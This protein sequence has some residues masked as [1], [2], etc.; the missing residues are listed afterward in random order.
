MDELKDS[1]LPLQMKCFECKVPK[2]Q[3]IALRVSDYIVKNI[4]YNY[5]KSKLLPK[6]LVCVLDKNVDVRKMALICLFNVLELIDRQ[7]INEQ[8]LNTLEK[9]KAGLTT[10]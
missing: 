4:D 9:L 7:T 2:L 1:I 3:D 5:T 8:V 6:I 10:P